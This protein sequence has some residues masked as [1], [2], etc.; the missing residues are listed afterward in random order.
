MED[1]GERPNS[2]V[3]PVSHPPDQKLTSTFQAPKNV[4]GKNRA[5]EVRLPESHAERPQLQFRRRDHVRRRRRVSRASDSDKL[6]LFDV[7]A[8]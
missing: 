8:A 3:L 2:R 1:V 6:E 5:M 7:K 4:R